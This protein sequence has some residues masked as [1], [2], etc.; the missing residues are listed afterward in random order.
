MK[1][2][3]DVMKGQRKKLNK[4]YRDQKMD[5]DWNIVEKKSTF[6]CPWEQTSGYVI[7]VYSD[8]M[9]SSVQV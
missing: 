9:T 5:S 2:A 1:K 4:D 7:N 3:R 6:H 8:V